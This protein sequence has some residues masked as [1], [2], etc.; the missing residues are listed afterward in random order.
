MRA[1][2]KQR[3]VWFQRALA[4][5]WRPVHWKGYL[6]LFGTFGVGLPCEG[7]ATFLAQHNGSKVVIAGLL[8]VSAAVWIACWVVSLLHSQSWDKRK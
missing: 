8:S 3:E 6:L 1:V 5:G 4:G 2:K 7:L